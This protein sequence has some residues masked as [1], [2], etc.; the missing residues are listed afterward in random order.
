M[1]G[2]VLAHIPQVV[3]MSTSLGAL[4][5]PVPRPLPG[6]TPPASPE[7]PSPQYWGWLWA[8]LVVVEVVD[9]GVVKCVGHKS[10]RFGGRNCWPRSRSSCW[11]SSVSMGLTIRVFDVVVVVAG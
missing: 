4:P 3:V 8:W 1:F 5:R 7:C 10:V 9:L 6:V 11:P 2:D